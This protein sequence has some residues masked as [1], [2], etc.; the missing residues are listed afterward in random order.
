MD[1]KSFL[2]EKRV[3]VENK[4]RTLFSAFPGFFPDAQGAMEYSLFSDGKRIRPGLAI[5]ACEAMDG[6]VSDVLPFRRRHRDDTH[7]FADP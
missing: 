5:A 2:A 4:L 6:D 1:L 7:L 3:L